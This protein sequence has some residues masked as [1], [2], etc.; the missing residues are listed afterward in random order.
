MIKDRAESGG[1]TERC[2]N[3]GEGDDEKNGRRQEQ[4]DKPWASQRDGSEDQSETSPLRTRNQYSIDVDSVD[5]RRL[6]GGGARGWSR[7]SKAAILRRSALARQL[8]I[9]ILGQEHFHM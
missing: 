5:G 4:E 7:L 3:D 2:Q 1:D 8:P 6:G 9:S